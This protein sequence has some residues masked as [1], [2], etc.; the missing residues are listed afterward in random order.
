MNSKGITP[1]KFCGRQLSAKG[2]FAF[3]ELVDS[4]PVPIHFVND[5]SYSSC[6][7]TYNR[8]DVKVSVDASVPDACFEENLLHELRHGFQ[9]TH[10]FPALVGSDKDER[11]QYCVTVVGS[12]I[13]DLDVYDYLTSRKIA[14]HNDMSKIHYDKLK[15]AITKHPKMENTNSLSKAGAVLYAADFAY[16]YLHYHK[17]K[18]KFLVDEVS[19]KIDKRVSEYFSIILKII[20]DGDHSTPEGV[21]SIFTCL[22]H[23]FPEMGWHILLMNGQSTDFIISGH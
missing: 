23:S 12:T 7:M 5:Q 1:E 2:L 17:Q 18:S 3:D 19:R 9:H 4:I 22:A 6:Q 20:E 10:G 14:V 16:L 15:Q 11:A 8:K 13:L 21:Q